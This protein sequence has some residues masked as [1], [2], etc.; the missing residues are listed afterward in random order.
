MRH[1]SH[2]LAAGLLPALALSAVLSAPL[3]AASALTQRR[4]APQKPTPQKK[5]SP[6]AEPAPTPARPAARQSPTPQ[7]VAVSAMLIRWQGRPG[8]NRYRLQVARDQGFA[9]IVFDQAVEGREYAVKGL[10][11]GNYFWRVAAAAA[12]TSSYSRPEPISLGQTRAA[13]EV[14]NVVVPADMGGWRTATGEVA[15]LV[16]ARLRSAAVVDFVGLGPDGRVFAV[17]GASGISLWTVRQTGGSSGASASFEPLVLEGSGGEATIVAAGE[18]GVRALRGETGREAWRARLEGK[19]ASGIAADLN[20]DGRAEAVVVTTDPARIYVLD[21]GTGAVAASDKLESEAVGAPYAFNSG[22]ARVLALARDDG[23]VEI[24]GADLKVIRAEKLGEKATTPPLVFA[25]GEDALLVVGTAKG[26]AALNVADLRVLGRIS[27]D[28]DMPRGAL[29]A[30]DVEGDGAPEIVM[31][32]RRGRL[33]LVSTTD[34]NVRWFVEGLTDAA[35]AAFADVD[36]DR[37]LD[38]IVAGGP[39]FAL[40]FS[41]RDGRLIYKVEEG[42]RATPPK[43]G[44][45]PR[46]LVAAPSPGGGGILV[47][48]DPA[49]QSLRAVEL[50]KGSVKT[51]SR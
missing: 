14:P 13:V 27:A 28:D 3:A 50:P 5:D 32:T 15:R 49:R 30:A 47:G 31:I 7:Q 16:P 6:A 43:S 51:A 23:G 21:G 48:S 20:G 9:D 18:G 26:L 39:A 34:G 42:G 4:R 35:S 10:A 37:V 29:T 46:T 24:R 8:V 33:A 45:E 12:E 11:P 38:V 1:A 44:A 2:P 22:G 40:G 25:R 19:P 17:D 41:G 36:G